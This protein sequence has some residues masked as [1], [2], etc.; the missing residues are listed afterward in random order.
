MLKY[1]TNLP[2]RFVKDWGFL[3]FIKIAD[4]KGERARE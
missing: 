3:I 1:R 2:G 4:E